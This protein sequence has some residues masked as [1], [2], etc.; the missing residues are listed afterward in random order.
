MPARWMELAERMAALVEGELRAAGSASGLNA[1]QVHVLRYLSKANRYSNTPSAAAAYFGLTKGTVSQT[2][3]A[4]ERGG[5][6]EKRPDEG[7][8][9]IVRLALTRKGERLLEGVEEQL[10]GV[11]SVRAL[12]ASLE[13]ALRAWQ[14]AR[15]GLSFG[16]CRTCR[17]FLT[18]AAG[19]HQCGLT[20][21]KLAAPQTV[22]ICREH[23]PAA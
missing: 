4:L 18:A 3:Q 22:K 21:E 7:D 17:H 16:V 12:E 8:G 19:G 13:G 5:W 9:R 1:A 10:G 14:Q 15:G 20:G 6:V 11:V 2:I 23:E